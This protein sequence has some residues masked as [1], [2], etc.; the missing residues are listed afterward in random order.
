MSVKREETTFICLVWL[1][2]LDY[3]ITPRAEQEYINKVNRTSEECNR[4]FDDD[5]WK[6][7]ETH[8][9]IT[10]ICALRK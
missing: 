3:G 5:D 1:K 2:T 10:C 7:W 4:D 6:I 8:H 9:I